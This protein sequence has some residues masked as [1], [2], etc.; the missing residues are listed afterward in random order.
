MVGGW[1]RAE[2]G[3]E[4]WGN[5]LKYLKRGWNRKEGRAGKRG[6]ETNILKR[7]VD[8]QVQGVG[9]SKSGWGG[10]GWNPLTNYDICSYI[11][12]YIYIYIQYI[13]IYIHTY[14]TYIYICV[15]V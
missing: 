7:G 6:G 11:S 3:C 1:I 2:G 9:D 8:K 5:C 15:C 13:Y 14:N 10:G 12:I 4:W